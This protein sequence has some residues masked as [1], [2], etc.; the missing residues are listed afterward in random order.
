MTSQTKI[1][2]IVVSTYRYNFDVKYIQGKY[3]ELADYLSRNP[4]WNEETEKHGPWITDDFRKEITIKAH[5]C[6]AQ[7]IRIFQDR[8]ANDPLLEEMRD[9]GAIDDQS[10]PYVEVGPGRN[11]FWMPIYSNF[12]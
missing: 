4:E 11:G 9:S 12:H 6:S 10:Q 1:S 3:N 8:I 7:T 5:V 2:D